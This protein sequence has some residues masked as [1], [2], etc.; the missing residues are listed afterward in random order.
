MPRDGN[1]VSSAAVMVLHPVVSTR[2]AGV[3]GN[4]NASSIALGG[5]LTGDNRG[6]IVCA[7]VATQ[8]V[9]EGG[10]QEAP[11]DSLLQDAMSIN[12]L[13]CRLNRCFPITSQIHCAYQ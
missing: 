5:R 8:V 3:V 1:C 9:A 4:D 2:R 6:T 7:R 11:L 12:Y 10:R 13:S